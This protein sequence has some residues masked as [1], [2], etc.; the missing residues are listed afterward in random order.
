[1][2]NW[3][4]RWNAN[5]RMTR[6][7]GQGGVGLG[8][9]GGSWLWRRSKELDMEAYLIFVIFCT[10]TH[11]KIVRQKSAK[12]H[13]KNCLATG[14]G[15]GRRLKQ[16]NKACTNE[17][18]DI[19]DEIKGEIRNGNLAANIEGNWGTGNSEHV[20]RKSLKALQLLRFT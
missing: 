17:L 1:M 3:L 16:T 8:K 12:I 14:V 18:H 19:M 7:S 5:A 15:Y 6:R 9:G 2:C 4:R 10:P 13:D 11:L 20:C